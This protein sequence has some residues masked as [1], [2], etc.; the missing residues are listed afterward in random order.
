LD[1]G[2]ADGGYTR[3]LRSYGVQA[4]VGVEVLLHRAQQAAHTP[5][6]PT[7][8]TYCCAESEV[9]PF[10]DATFDGVLVNEVLEHVVDEEATLR[11]IQRVLRPGGHLALMAPNRWF[12]FEGHGMRLAGQ[13]I[14]VPI[15]LLPWL[16]A[17]LTARVLNAR[18]YWPRDLRQLVKD[19]GL[20]IIV[21][22][23]VFPVL[24]VYPWLPA[25]LMPRYRRLV[26]LLERIPLVRRLGVSTLIIAKRPTSH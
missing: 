10:A 19:A 20:Q 3:A 14:W 16:P 22:Q 21:M 1:C 4:V 13:A 8:I 11:E 25:A 18:N 23:S 17:R 26:P 24:E 5:E 2:C 9:L 12:P 15:P 6:Q 7:G